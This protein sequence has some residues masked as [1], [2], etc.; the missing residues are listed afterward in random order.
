MPDPGVTGASVELG[1]AIQRLS[2]VFRNA[3]IGTAALDARLLVSHAC[4]FSRE[5]TISKRGFVLTPSMTERMNEVAARRLAGEPVS[6]IVGRREFWGLEFRLSRHTLD[7]RPETELLVEAVLEYVRE[8]GLTR[9]PL[10]ILDLG[11]GTGC[12]LGAILSELPLVYGVGVDLS[13]DA[14]DVAQE[15]LS[16]LGL[17]HRAAFLCA[18]W[19]SALSDESFDIIVGNPPYICSADIAGLGV[20]VRAYD[21]RIAL[22]G[23]EDGLEAYRAILAQAFRVL[24]GDGLLVLE[25]GHTQAQVVREM[26]VRVGAGAIVE[27]RVLTDLREWERAVAGVRQLGRDEPK[28]KKKVGNPALSG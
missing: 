18:S 26:M 17:P 15:N 2:A 27:A 11:T 24:R 4:G 23:G 1:D 9:S 6:R 8:E 22:D 20:E 10:R 28:S 19:M 12:I 5:E 21:P 14:L 25:T 13:E 7:P 16:R 3:G